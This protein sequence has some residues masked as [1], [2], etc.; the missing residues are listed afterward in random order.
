M[1]GKLIRVG[2]R[3]VSYRRQIAG[4]LMLPVPVCRRPGEPR[5]NNQRPKHS[6]RPDHIAENF[7][8]APNACGFGSLFR[9]SVLHKSRE[10]LLSAVETASLQ[11]FLGTDD[12]QRFEQL[13]ADDVLAA[14]AAS[15]RK[16]RNTG[17]VTAG[18]AGEQTGILV[19]RM[20]RRV[21]CTRDR[22]QTL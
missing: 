13:R 20:R 18:E 10:E 2:R 22:L 3:F 9:E 19:V 14:L 5:N 17:V 4:E 7:F 12:A 6:D 1:L 11:Q 15:Q 16:V 8:L 21:H